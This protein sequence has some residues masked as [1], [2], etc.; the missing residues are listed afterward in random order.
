[1]GK[2]VLAATHLVNSRVN[3]HGGLYETIGMLV[4]KALG[5][6]F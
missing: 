3:D 2:Q 1:M 4:E 5:F 6:E